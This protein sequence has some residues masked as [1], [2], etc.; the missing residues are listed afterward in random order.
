ML[1]ETPSGFKLMLIF[2]LSKTSAEPHFDDTA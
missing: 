1:S 2:N